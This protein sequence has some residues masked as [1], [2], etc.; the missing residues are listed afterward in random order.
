MGRQAGNLGPKRHGSQSPSV[1]PEAQLPTK[2]VS[3]HW[4]LYCAH[5]IDKPSLIGKCFLAP[6]T[7]PI[8]IDNTGTYHLGNWAAKAAA[9][10]LQI[11]SIL[12]FSERL[13]GFRNIFTLSAAKA[14]HRRHSH[15]A[16]NQRAEHRE[17]RVEE[18]FQVPGI[19]RLGC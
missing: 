7:R 1:P 10:R 9:V 18:D 6:Y 4:P 16:E 12:R 19:Q 8:F 13:R 14:P 17:P 11:L 15:E 5:I 2:Y 3:V